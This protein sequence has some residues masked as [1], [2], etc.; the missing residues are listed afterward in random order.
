VGIDGGT[1]QGALE[2]PR[3]YLRQAGADFGTGTTWH[4]AAGI[5]MLNKELQDFTLEAH[6]AFKSADVRQIA[7][8]EI[9]LLDLRYPPS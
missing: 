2:S 6:I 5:K 9:Y 8:L 4:G 7:R 3:S 1:I